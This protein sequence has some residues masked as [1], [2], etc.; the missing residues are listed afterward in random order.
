MENLSYW[1]VRPYFESFKYYI[2]LN[3]GFIFIC[4][5]WISIWQLDVFM[6]MGT[7]YIEVVCNIVTFSNLRPIHQN[8]IQ[9]TVRL[10]WLQFIEFW[11]L[12]DRFVGLVKSDK[13]RLHCN[14]E[15]SFAHFSIT[16]SSNYLPCPITSFSSDEEF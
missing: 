11:G 14:I 5:T 7:I 3:L 13:S 16:E 10:I 4:S 15:I 12:T 6:P 2:F 1:K 9:I 8:I